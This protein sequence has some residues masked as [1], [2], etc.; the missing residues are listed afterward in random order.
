[1]EEW[2]DI[3]G[4]EGYYQAS[5]MG[6]LRSVDRIVLC[7]G[8]V[9]R[10]QKGRILKSEIGK[11]GYYK[12]VLHVNGKG[13][14]ERVH[15]LIASAFIPN[16]YNKPQVNHKD[17]NKINNNVENLEWC[18]PSENAKHA[19]RTGLLTPNLENAHKASREATRKPVLR[20][21]GVLFESASEAAKKWE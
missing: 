3:P 8:N 17:G 18:T 7:S 19:I 13:K 12:Q 10:P 16:P 6:R 9:K 21:D 5:S 4:Y 15:R 1:M 14:T 11:D 2:R 20:S